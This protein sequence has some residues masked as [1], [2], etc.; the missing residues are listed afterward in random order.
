[1]TIVMEEELIRKRLT[2][3]KFLHS[4]LISRGIKYI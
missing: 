4:K 1:M 3:N 2:L